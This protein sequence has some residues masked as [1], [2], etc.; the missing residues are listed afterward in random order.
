MWRS[1]SN[2]I[3]KIA[4]ALLLFILQIAASNLLPPPW[5]R[6]NLIFIA[7]MLIMIFNRQ[8]KFIWYVFGLSLLSELFHSAPFGLNTAALYVAVAALDWLLINIL[9]NRFFLIVFIAGLAGI[10]IYRSAYLVLAALSH[11]IFGTAFELNALLMLDFLF[12]MLINAFALT[13]IYLV[14]VLFIK[15]FNPRYLNER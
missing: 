3:A 13:V 1:I 12:E 14:P 8:N 6:L 15:K 9:T 11:Y 2:A 7:A 4:A 10:F 5:S